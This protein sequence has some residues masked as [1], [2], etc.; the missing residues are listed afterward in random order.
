MIDDNLI[1]LHWNL[2]KV[3]WLEQPDQSTFYRSDAD[4]QTFIE[5]NSAVTSTSKTNTKPEI[6][7][8]LQLVEGRWNPVR[9]RRLSC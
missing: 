3:G 9:L 8:K 2:R 4:F 6:C 1:L 5:P 7:L